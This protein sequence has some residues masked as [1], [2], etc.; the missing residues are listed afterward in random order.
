MTISAEILCDS[1]APN[2]SRLTTFLLEYPR[3]IHAEL[4]THRVF[5]K[6][7]ASSRAIPIDKMISNV[8]EN[9]V[10]PIF[11]KNQKGMAASI[12]M[13]GEELLKAEREW[14][15]ALNLACVQAIRLSELG[16]HKQIANRVLEPFSHIKVVLS[17]T[18]FEN[19]FELRI[20]PEAQ[21]DIQELAI[22]MRDALLKSKFKFMNKYEW[23]LPFITDEEKEDIEAST[24]LK[25]SVARCARVSYGNFFN[26]KTLEDDINLH[27]KLLASKHMSPF[28]HV[29][30]PASNNPNVVISNFKGWHQ[31][32]HMVTK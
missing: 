9:P 7:S 29:A 17:G 31:L 19:F 11:M 3:Y 23:H 15:T 26:D 8:R 10:K 2:G 30:R 22:Q 20:S 14:Q 32:R 12:K 18:E 27:D 1:M 24:L 28:E 6:N 16:V 5:S 21:Q 4:L 25:I 13:E